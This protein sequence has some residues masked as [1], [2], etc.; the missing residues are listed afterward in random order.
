MP[1]TKLT[2]IQKK[3]LEALAGA[4]FSL[5]WRLTGGAALIGAYT[6]HR[7]TRDLDLFFSESKLGAIP[8]EIQETLTQKG[9]TVTPIQ[10]SP[11]FVRF[12]VEAKDERVILDLVADNISPIE[13]PVAWKIEGA[14]I[15][16]DTP[17]EILVNKLCGLLSRSEL[18]DLVDLEALLNIGGDLD[19][20]LQDAPQKDAGF[21]PLTLGWVL[22][23]MPIEMLAQTLGLSDEDA[24]HL[25]EFRD[26]LVERVVKTTMS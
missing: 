16:I 7:A 9:F 4:Q 3:L 20:A 1:D 25:T 2:N 24:K 21:S 11:A 8:R 17:H 12:L 26:I 23:G 13:E 14:D 22:K 15:R 10:S 6:H 19:R 18:R 5:P